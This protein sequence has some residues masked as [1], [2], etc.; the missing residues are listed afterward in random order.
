MRQPTVAAAA[1]FLSI[2]CRRAAGVEWGRHYSWPADGSS[3]VDR[4]RAFHIADH[5]RQ[6]LAR[7]EELEEPV[8]SS[9]GPPGPPGPPGDEGP[10]G[11]TGERGLQGDAGASG[12]PG[13]KGDRGPKGPKGRRGES[14]GFD[15]GK[16]LAVAYMSAAKLYALAA[17]VGVHFCLIGLVAICLF[18]KTGRRKRSSLAWA[19]AGSTESLP[20]GCDEDVSA[21]WR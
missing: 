9:I 18:T 8:P 7:R 14:P 11:P 5:R 17:V 3:F 1:T 16:K 20:E 4:D 21:S 6:R 19:G 10:R 2:S 15:E 12:Q 13:A